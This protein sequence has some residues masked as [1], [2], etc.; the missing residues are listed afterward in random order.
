MCTGIWGKSKKIWDDFN[1]SPLCKIAKFDDPQLRL[2]S[3][4][5]SVENIQIKTIDIAYSKRLCEKF[6]QNVWRPGVK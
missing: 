6:Y 2:T 5:I 4:K 3:M 1:K